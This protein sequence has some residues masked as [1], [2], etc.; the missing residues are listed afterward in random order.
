MPG[1][2]KRHFGIRPRIDGG[3][4]GEALVLRSVAGVSWNSADRVQAGSFGRWMEHI[5]LLV[6]VA[7]EV[8]YELSPKL[9]MTRAKYPIAGTT[10]PVTID[11]DDPTT[12]GIEW[13]EVPEIDAWIA[14]GHPVFTDPATVERELTDAL[15]AHGKR[16]RQSA[17][18]DAAWRGADAMG[19]DAGIDPDALGEMLVRLQGPVEEQAAQARRREEPL[20]GGRPTARI[21]AATPTGDSFDGDT[22]KH[23][24]L[25]SV[26]DPAGQRHG[27][28]WRGRIRRGKLMTEWSDIVVEVDPRKPGRVTILWDAV[29]DGLAV[30]AQRLHAAGDELEARL[31][32]GPR[33][34]LSMLLDA[35]PADPL[36]A[37][38]CLAQLRTAGAVTESEF[39]ARKARLLD[40]I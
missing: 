23:E 33:A 15:K 21:L 29:P 13:D 36:D 30:A 16:T 26:L 14:A 10:L 38:E 8:P 6:R 20:P 34:D 4:R 5:P 31:A 25:L 1:S 22:F 35:L 3:V 11:R 7:G 37:L 32:A 24:L 27:A 39:E 17:M 2:A 12:L 40:Q 19:A 28:R 9:W 18:R